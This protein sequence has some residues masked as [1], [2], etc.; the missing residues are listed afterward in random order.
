MKINYKYRILLN[1]FVSLLLIIL[2]SQLSKSLSYGRI[3]IFIVVSTIA[4]ISLNFVAGVLG[5]TVLGHAAFMLIGGVVSAIFTQKFYTYFSNNNILLRESL[6]S[7]FISILVIIIGGIAA[8]IVGFLVSIITIG[9]LK[10]DYLAIITIAISIV[11]LTIANNLTI[12]G[13]NIGLSVAA[14]NPTSP[15]VATVFLILTLTII[16]LIVKSRHG[17]AII[18]IREDSIAAESSGIPVKKYKIITFTIAT[19][20]AGIAGALYYHMRGV[21]INPEK[22]FGLDKSIELFIIIVLGGLGSFTGGIISSIFINFLVYKFLI[23]EYS[24]YQKLIY[25]VILIVVMLFKP[26]GLLGIKE[27]SWEW[28]FKFIKDLPKNIKDIPNKIKN[29]FIKTKESFLKFISKLKKNKDEGDT[30]V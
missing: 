13:G 16:M 1:I 4:V 14:Y 10:G 6:Y 20:F 28:F 8:A 23:I 18:S 27:F 30:Y 5:E 7:P 29:K 15:I 21:G 24:L 22:N 19:F 26:K 3:V 17:R 11:I 25:G 9:R 2:V 12:T